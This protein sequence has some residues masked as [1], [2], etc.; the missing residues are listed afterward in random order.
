M[1]PAWA[2][3]SWGWPVSHEGLPASHR[4]TGRGEGG[5]FP[6]GAP[7]SPNP[8]PRGMA[9]GLFLCQGEVEG[10]GGFLQ[11]C[12]VSGHPRVGQIRDAQAHPGLGRQGKRMWCLK[13][14]G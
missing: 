2:P 7:G 9:L 11:L 13:M 5:D 10:V 8:H 3:H 4:A 14:L 6:W 12:L 1:T